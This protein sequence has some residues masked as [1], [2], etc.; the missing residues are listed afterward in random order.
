MLPSSILVLKLGALQ[1]YGAVVRES[2]V[3]EEI[4]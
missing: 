4:G 3:I 2:F 1:Q